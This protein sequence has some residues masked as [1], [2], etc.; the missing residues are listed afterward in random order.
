MHLA[1]NLVWLF[2][3]L[4]SSFFVCLYFCISCRY[5]G[6]W[7]CRWLILRLT[8]WFVKLSWLWSPFF[9]LCV[10]FYEWLLVSYFVLWIFVGVIWFC[11]LFG[12][13]IG[14]YILMDLSCWFC[15]WIAFVIAFW[16]LSSRLKDITFVCIFWKFW[17]FQKRF[18][19]FFGDL[20]AY[21]GDWSHVPRSLS[22]M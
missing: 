2:Q 20:P 16:H 13:L 11:V 14:L 1:P 21:L 4:S 17:K 5:L 12:S 10:L 19:F 9:I 3:L 22:Y 6:L 15:D 18:L 8:L 7:L